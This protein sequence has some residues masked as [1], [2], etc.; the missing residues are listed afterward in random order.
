MPRKVDARRALRLCSHAA[1]EQI[2]VVDC[3]FHYSAKSLL[4]TPLPHGVGG[5]VAAPRGEIHR[6]TK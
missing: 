3:Q 4:P 2:L 6:R 5:A 1:V